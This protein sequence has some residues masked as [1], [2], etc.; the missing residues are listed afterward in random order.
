VHFHQVSLQK[1]SILLL[2]YMYMYYRCRFRFS[3][4]V[5]QTK[6]V[7]VGDP[8]HFNAKPGPAFHCGPRSETCPSPKW[9]ISAT[10][11]HN[12]LQRSILSL[13][14]SMVSV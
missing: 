13:H 5:V 3:V 11:G 1:S 14:A 2:L 4:I 10:T 8:N 9:F 6:R 12:I 7:P